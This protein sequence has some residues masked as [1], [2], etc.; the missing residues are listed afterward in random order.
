MKKLAFVL[1]ILC[2]VNGF[3]VK[4]QLP[5]SNPVYRQLDFWLGK[6]EAFGKNGKLAGTSHISSIL[7][8]CIVLEEWTSASLQQGLRYAGKSFNTYNVATKQWQQTWVDNTGANTAYLRGEAKKDTVIFY[9]DKV[10]EGRGKAFMR[11]LS[12][13]K[14]N[15]DR[16]R[17]LGERSDDEGNTWTVEYDLEYRRIK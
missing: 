2:I 8:S 5:C 3:L 1:T 17:Q 14:L 6:W 13:I 11:R 7:D 9:A 10:E 12:F 16:V 4:A 15:T